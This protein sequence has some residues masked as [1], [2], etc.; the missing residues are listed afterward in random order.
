MN[1]INLVVSTLRG[2]AYSV[3]LIVVLTV[4][5]ELYIATTA[6]GK[7]VHPLKDMLAS[8]HG[9]HWVG[10]GIWAVILFVVVS[11]LK[12]YS[13]RNTDASDKLT[14]YT[15]FLSM[16]LIIGTLVLF[17]FMIFEYV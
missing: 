7:V 12:Y 2:A 11:L 15:E 9:H 5:G 8:L 16:M 14:P 4:V 6:A 3:M 17:G 13:L 10:K 1:K